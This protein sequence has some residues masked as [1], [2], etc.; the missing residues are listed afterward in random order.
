[1]TNKYIDVRNVTIDIPIFD[2]NRS[3]RKSLFNRC[4]GKLGGQIQLSS[5]NHAY[6]RALHDVSFRLNEGDRLGLIG[7]NGS[8][9]TTLL[10]TLA[11]IYLPHQ[12][13]I[14]TK[15][16]ITQLFNPSLGLDIEDTGYENI[17]AMG[18]FLGLS[19]IAIDKK[20]DEIIEFSELGDFI[21]SPVRTY[22]AGMQLRLSFAIITTL[23]P[24]ILLLDEGIGAG[25]AGFANKAAARMES[26]Y[27]R[28]SILVIASHSDALIKQL[29]NKAMLLEHGKIL[30]FGAIDEVLDFYQERVSSSVV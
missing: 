23:E 21:H 30:K 3:L 1:M 18:L 4:T 20:I 8:G 13:T 22:S 6:V 25:D 15:G 7:H 29:C 17:Y 10:N 14:Y 19:R 9:K 24:E 16:K 28:V 11:G 2:T 27:E 12:G 5:R 26:F